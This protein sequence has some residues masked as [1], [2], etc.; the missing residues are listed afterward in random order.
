MQGCI[1]F[2]RRLDDVATDAGRTAVDQTLADG[3]LLLGKSDNFLIAVAKGAG[4][5][6]VSADLPAL[7]RA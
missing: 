3:Q 6:A 7:D 2:H 1:L 4:L 5:E